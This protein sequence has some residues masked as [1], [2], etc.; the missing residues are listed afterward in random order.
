MPINSYSILNNQDIRSDYRDIDDHYR[1]VLRNGFYAGESLNNPAV[2]SFC[3]YLTA[4][5]DLTVSVAQ[6]IMD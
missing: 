5:M 1:G 3:L 2:Y 6:N 4:I